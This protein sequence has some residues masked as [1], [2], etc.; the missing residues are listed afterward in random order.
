MSCSPVPPPARWYGPLAPR[1]RFPAQAGRGAALPRAL[2]A[3]TGGERRGRWG[4][5]GAAGEGERAQD[6][7]GCGQQLSGARGWGLSRSA[8][9]EEA[10]PGAG[11]RG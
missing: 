1:R 11:G 10:A 4:R 6:A 9:E 5:R 3:G 7:R 8:E 2:T